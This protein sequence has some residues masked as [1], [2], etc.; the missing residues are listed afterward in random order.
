MLSFNSYNR[1][2]L[3]HRGRRILSLGEFK[4][5][6]DAEDALLAQVSMMEIVLFY[7]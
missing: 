1:H 7:Y 6:E 5:K 2:E 3:S 4:N